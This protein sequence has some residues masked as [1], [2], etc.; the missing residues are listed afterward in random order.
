MHSAIAEC[1][2]LFF[3]V[4]QVLLGAARKRCCLRDVQPSTNDFFSPQPPLY[5][6][7]S[8]PATPVLFVVPNAVFFSSTLVKSCSALLGRDVV[9]AMSSRRLM[10]F[11]PLS[12]LYI[13]RVA[14]PRHLFCSL[15]RSK[16]MYLREIPS[17]V[18]AFA[19]FG[20]LPLSTPLPTPVP[21]AYA[22]FHV[23]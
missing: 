5:S 13:A 19:R 20:L 22:V 15:W 3:H 18:R 2:L 10:I 11:S 14:L 23:Y 9:C 16:K 7:S 8:A 1:C 12:R 21:R 6:S 4:G 17:P